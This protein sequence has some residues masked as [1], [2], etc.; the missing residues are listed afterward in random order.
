MY[1]AQDN[2]IS[3]SRKLHYWTSKL[4]HNDFRCF[5]I[6]AE[7]LQDSEAELF[8]ETIND[9]KD[10]LAG[11]SE[12]LTMYFPNFEHRE[13]YRVQHPFRLTGKPQRFLSADYVKLIEITSDTQLGAKFEEVPLDVFWRNLLE[14]YIETSKQ[15]MK[16][17]LPL[18]TKYLCESGFSRYANMKTKCRSKLDATSDIRLQLPIIKPNVKRILMS[19]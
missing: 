10:E 6:L 2:M 9:S 4:E 14:E 1:R 13:H 12:S 11:L 19:E 18:A 7:F 16:I 3:F 8:A 17:L 5:P 15:A